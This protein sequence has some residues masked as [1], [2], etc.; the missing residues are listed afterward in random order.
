MARTV[1]VSHVR[2]CLWMQVPI[3]VVLVR[4]QNRFIPRIL[5][6]SLTQIMLMI[7]DPYQYFILSCLYFV[8]FLRYSALNNSVTMKSVLEV[9]Q[10][11]SKWYHLKDPKN[12]ITLVSMI[13]K[14]SGN[15]WSQSFVPDTKT[16]ILTVN[17]SNCQSDTAAR[18]TLAIAN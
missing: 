3:L 13:S 14:T 4:Q 15:T 12:K 11:H 6:C 7:F 2:L 9:T 18:I 10:G 17:D 5:R 1:S 16:R 8:P